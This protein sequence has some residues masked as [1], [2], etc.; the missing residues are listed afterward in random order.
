MVWEVRP[1][2]VYCLEGFGFIF[3]VGKWE[4][5]SVRVLD[6]GRN[7]RLE[8]LG[9]G[10]GSVR[11]CSPAV[12]YICRGF[13]ALIYSPATFFLRARFRGVCERGLALRGG[14]HCIVWVLRPE[15][16]GHWAGLWIFFIFGTRRGVCVFLRVDG[17][18]A[19]RVR[20]EQQRSFTYQCTAALASRR[21]FP[22]LFFGTG[23]LECHFVFVLET[24]ARWS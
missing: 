23:R 22:V 9:G 21:A 5:G 7:G 6:N 13:W 11:R 4:S 24:G 15:G 8:I 14:A 2:G 18:G 12:F 1:E 20:E 10:A 19:W 3:E 16:V 17:G